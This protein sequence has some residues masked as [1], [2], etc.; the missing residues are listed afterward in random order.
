MSSFEYVLFADGSVL[1]VIDTLT[2]EQLMP[3]LL[4][5]ATAVEYYWPYADSRWGCIGLHPNWNMLTDISLM[6]VNRTL[7][8]PPDVIK[9]AHMLE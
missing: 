9:L 4:E 2:F 3:I 7:N 5:V 1:P 6:A 8:E